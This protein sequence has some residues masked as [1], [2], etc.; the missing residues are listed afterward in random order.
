MSTQ[1][2]L[3]ALDEILARDSDSDSD[4][5][6]EESSCSTTVCSTS[7]EEEDFDSLDECLEAYSLAEYIQSQNNLN[8]RQRVDD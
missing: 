8:K 1:H 4:S 6:D 7:S 2:E 5:L 3:F